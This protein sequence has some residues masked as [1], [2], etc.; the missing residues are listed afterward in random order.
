MYS[1]GPTVYSYPHVGNYRA[2]LCR[3]FLRRT[4]AVFGYKLKYVMNITDVGHLESD[5]DT[6]EDKMMKAAKRENKN[7][8]EIA[9]FY[10]KVFFDDCEKLNILKPDVVAPATDYIQPMIA[11]VQALKD[12]GYTYE[13]G[14]NV[15]FDVSKFPAYADFA[16][17]R[18]DKQ[19]ESRVDE[20]SNKK[21]PYDFV[22]WFSNSKFKNQ[23]MQWES[24]F[25]KGFPGWHL[26]CSAIAYENLGERLD[27]HAGG[28]D[29]IPVHHTNEIAQSEA[30]LGHKWVNYWFHNEFMNIASEKISKSLGNAVLI[31]DLEKQGFNP[32]HFRLL[33]FMSHYRSQADFT[34]DNMSAAKTTYEN[35]RLKVI[36][37]RKAADND[38]NIKP[39]CAA[40]NIYLERF[41]S[42][43]AD[44][45]NTPVALSVLFDVLKSDLSP[46]DKVL[47]LEKMDAVLG[48]DVHTFREKELTPDI[49]K[50][51]DERAAAR[52]NKDFKR[53]D[54]LRDA[55]LSKGVMVKDA[56]DGQTFTLL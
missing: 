30:R 33:C 13:A 52:K 51:L 20:D 41:Y 24:P 8:Y 31:S 14:G 45:V 55:L 28:V 50:L 54:E 23:I 11:F 42:A 27:I 36:E 44:D 47:I 21:N 22:V 49:K 38:K 32:L 1:C 18:L 48:L 12:K 35:L 9:A 7:P 40:E 19:T 6:G 53:S 56:K 39:D 17:L 4:L 2:Y 43:L 34:L 3:D 10:T 16:R 37:L 25:G 29:H 15:Y 46:V 26:E 5:G